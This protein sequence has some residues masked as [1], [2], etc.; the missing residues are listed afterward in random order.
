MIPQIDDFLKVCISKTHVFT[1][2]HTLRQLLMSYKVFFL[3]LLKSYQLPHVVLFTTWIL[4]ALIDSSN[5]FHLESKWVAVSQHSP[6]TCLALKIT[7][8]DV[9]C[10]WQSEAPAVLIP[11]HKR[12]TIPFN[13][14]YLQKYVCDCS[15]HWT[16]PVHLICV[17]FNKK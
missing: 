16:E 15:L 2:T 3:N 9:V 7:S 13:W 8:I 1:P 10:D 17:M 11:F 12:S 4:E 5:G 14:M 6:T